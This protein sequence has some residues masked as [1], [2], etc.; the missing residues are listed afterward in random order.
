MKIKFKNVCIVF[1]GELLR[2]TKS[3]YGN[4]NN[5]KKNLRECDLSEESFNR[6]DNIMKSIIKHIIHPYKKK[7]YKV[8]VSGCVY[9]CPNYYNNLNEFFPNNTIKKIKPGKTNQAEVFHLSIEQAEN[10][11]PYCL[12]YISIRAD[13]MMLKNININ[14]LS[15]LYTCFGWE[16]ENLPEVDVFW[17][18]SKNTITIF[19]KILLNIGYKRQYVA[20]HSILNKLKNNNVILYPI[21]TDYKNQRT[22]I[23][24][25]V[26]IN[27]L[28][29]HKNRP[30]INYMRNLKH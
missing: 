9:E 16:N 6:Q 23:P 18:I 21:W 26:Y 17:I 29:T 7:G 10:E 22:G 5:Y 30:F 1:R 3:N 8:F 25:D 15:G 28:D 12:E 19:K 24:Y 13:Y 14:K 4:N 2:N 20:T 11:H 27:D